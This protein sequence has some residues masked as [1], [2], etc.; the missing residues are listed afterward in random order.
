MQNLRILIFIITS[1]SYYGSLQEGNLKNS[2]LFSDDHVD[3]HYTTSMQVRVC[4]ERSE[5]KMIL[6][7]L[8]SSEDGVSAAE[9]LGLPSSLSM[10]WFNLKK[11]SK[12]IIRPCSYGGGGKEKSEMIR[13][14]INSVDKNITSIS[15]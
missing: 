5:D 7:Y 14:A 10:P 3:S 9:L 11:K 2:V 8:K 13:E 12:N 4:I 15:D 1:S 6:A